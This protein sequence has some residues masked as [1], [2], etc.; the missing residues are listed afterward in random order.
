MPSS[1]DKRKLQVLK[2][3]IHEYLDTAEPVSSG[4]LVEKYGL[5]VS[6]ATIRNDMADL[7]AKGLLEQPHTSAGRIPTDA[8][9]RLYV[10]DL[11]RRDRRSFQTKQEFT[12]ALAELQSDADTSVRDFAKAVADLTNE[13][14]V[15]RF[16]SE[17]VHVAGMANLVRKPE[18]RES[19]LLVALTEMFD[20]IDELIQDVYPR[21]RS[22]I[23]VYIGSENPFGESLSSILARYEMPGF[24]PGLVGIL[25]PTR[26]D[27]DANIEMLRFIDE[28]FSEI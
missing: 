1:S 26:M 21:V 9:Y 24:G 10:D 14:V 20:E 13:A 12:K 2:A 11:I 22:G 8:G 17:E 18:F 7:E 23:K 25:G 3:I 16:S 15:V 27:Y 6:P 19:D 28:A 4:T 5:G